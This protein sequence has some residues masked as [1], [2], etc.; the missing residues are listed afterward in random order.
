MTRI[1]FESVFK[2]S[3]DA[4]DKGVSRKVNAGW[5]PDGGMIIHNK[6]DGSTWF[7]QRFFRHFEEKKSDIILPGEKLNK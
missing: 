7:Y 3:I 4:F 1:E 2:D 6:S 5:T